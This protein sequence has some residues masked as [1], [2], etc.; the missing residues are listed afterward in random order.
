PRNSVNSVAR[1]RQLRQTKHIHSLRSTRSLSAPYLLPICSLSAPYQIPL[2][3]Q[4]ENMKKAG[5]NQEK[6]KK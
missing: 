3:R 6:T 1:H 4:G 2:Y 5:S